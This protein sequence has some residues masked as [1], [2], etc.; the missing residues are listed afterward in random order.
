[1][2]KQTRARTVCPPAAAA[3]RPARERVLGAAFKAFTEN[4]YAETT[5]LAIATRAKVS[6]RE[7]YALFGNKQAVLVAC[8]TARVARMRPPDLPA[9]RDRDELASMLS[10]FG[11]TLL[12][13][14]CHPAVMAMFRLGIAEVDRSPEVAQALTA[15]GR[16]ANHATV[17]GLLA[18]AQ[19]Q[20]LVGAGAPPQMAQ[21]F[22]ALLWEDL[23]LR[24]LLRVADRPQ[25]EEIDA[26]ARRA[27]A[28]L[29]QLYPKPEAP[30]R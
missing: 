9:P 23:M 26:R 6:K 28:A 7:L 3:D 30:T 20:G 11:A 4:G 14:V 24:L 21:Q 16:D 18:Q 8:I 27:S 17:A 12:R 10:A 22:L 29:L 25:Q 13:E 19:S 5:T 2:A 15:A 1:M